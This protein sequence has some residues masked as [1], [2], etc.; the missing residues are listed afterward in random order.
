VFPALIACDL[1]GTLLRDDG[2]LGARTLR[3]LEA[4]AAR[5]ALLVLCTARPVRWVRPLAA[6]LAAHPLAACDNGAVI[7]DLAA[8]RLV[9]QSALDGADARAV[10]AAVASA[11]PGGAWA[12]ERAD[13]FAHEPGY[14]PHWPVPE[15]TMVADVE[16]LLDQPA[17]KLMFRHAGHSA[18][19]MLGEARRA[20]ANRAEVTHS[21]SG[22]DLL[23]I[24]A[25]GV[26]KASA[27][28]RICADRAIPSDDV[29]AFGDMPNDLAMLD[30]AGCAVAVAGAHPDVLAAADEVTL[31]N[32]EEGVAATLER[33]LNAPAALQEGEG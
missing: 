14:R 12:V 27:L 16:R 32:D 19:A 26:S 17:V 30:W 18:D 2:S 15:G 21:N 23:E 33:M 10:V 31:G 7:W 20:A 22:G 3:V 25:P 5:G 29:I 13:G 9:A 11:L 1:D 24:S 6:A 8:D 28:A 4:W